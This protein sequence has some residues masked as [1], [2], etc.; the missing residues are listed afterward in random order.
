LYN[1]QSG[2]PFGGSVPKILYGVCI[3]LLAVAHTA[4]VA[5]VL[6]PGNAAERRSRTYDVIHYRIVVELDEVDKG[7]NGTTSITVT[8]LS[9]KLDSLVF[10]AAEMNVHSVSLQ[11]RTL[12][13]ANRSPYLTVFLDKPLGLSDTVTVAIQY[14]CKPTAGLYFIQPDSTDPKRRRQIWS[15]G[16]DTDNHFWFPCY[17]YPNDKATS[18]VIA[19]VPDWYVALSNGRLLTTTHNPKKRTK[20]FHWFESKPHSSYLIMIVAGEYDVVSEQYPGFPLQYYVYK[21]RVQDGVRSLA[22]T[23]AAMKFFE[24]KIGVPYPWEKYAQIWIS[25]FMWGGMENVSAVTLNDETYLLDARAQVDFTSDDVVAHE[26]AHQ[27]W[28]DLVTSRDWSNLWLHEGFANYFEALFKQHQKG[29]D[30]FQYDLMQQAA[31]V[32][33]TEDANGRSPLV[34]KDGY[35][36]NVYSKGCWVL[37]MLR[38]VLGEDGFWKAIRLYAQRYAF[39]NADTYE[40]ILAVEDATGK[41]LT[42]FFDQWVYKTGHPKVKVNSVWSEDTKMLQ[43]EFIQTQKADSVT[44]VFKFPLSIE[45]VTSAKTIPLSVFIDQQQ[46]QVRIPLSE[47][48]L[49]VVVDKRKSVLATFDMQRTKEEYLYQLSHAGDIVDRIAAA[50]ELQH[51]NNDSTVFTSLRDAALHDRFWAV[52]NQ[53]TLSLA[54]SDDQPVAETLLEIY[55]DKHSSV[56]TSAIAALSHFPSRAVADAAWNAALSDSSYLVLSACIGVLAEIDSARGF[57]LAAR[58]VHMESY[59]N[60]IRR[61]AMHA[62]LTLKD[63]RSI[64]I[65]VPYTGI[66]NPADIRRLA[67]QILGKAGTNDSE[68]QKRLVYLVNDNDISIRKTAIEALALV[69]K[70]EVAGT[71]EQRRLVEP[72]EAV[73]KAI[74]DAL[75]TLSASD[76]SDPLKAK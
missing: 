2:F 48:P 64:P 68:S 71:L 39:K 14:S 13:F 29:D 55:N 36:A 17:D 30:Y 75:H 61:A 69:G 35:T 24:E 19:T 73:K 72:D 4:A 31:S 63:T 49:M 10:D 76:S 60:I 40:F 74:D 5:Q 32:F 3:C 51:H 18:E 8:P 7:V 66:S 21:D 25:K 52:R 23:S 22:K 56:R 59:R 20:T 50:K 45:C 26:L 43:L 57:D 65:V 12:R 16:E 62:L 33:N 46:Q 67:V 54:S 6:F 37:H 41:N 38:D 11:S 34:G 1:R 47:R 44:G 58:S 53:A 70:A 9:V 15:Q 28:G 27:W 42:W